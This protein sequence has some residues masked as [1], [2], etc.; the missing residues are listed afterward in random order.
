MH[1]SNSA[2]ET[3]VGAVRATVTRLTEMATSSPQAPAEAG[4][5]SS[6]TNELP[7]CDTHVHHIHELALSRFNEYLAMFN[8]VWDL[9]GDVV[10]AYSNGDGL[11]FWI[12]SN[13]LGE[14][15]GKQQWK[16]GEWGLRQ[17]L[18]CVVMLQ[19]FLIWSYFLHW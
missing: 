15:V 8:E 9:L 1:L 5:A 13:A 2:A 3:V 7:A 4:V 18:R 12:A 17:S 6:T 11:V 10:A 16:F 14:S 19:C